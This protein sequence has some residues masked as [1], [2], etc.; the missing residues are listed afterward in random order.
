MDRSEIRE[1]VLRSH[2][3][4]SGVDLDAVVEAFEALGE[5]FSENPHV[6]D[7]RAMA[8]ELMARDAKYVEAATARQVGLA[9]DIWVDVYVD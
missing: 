2:P 1:Y 8:G 7:S 9:F 5:V 3:E 6:L 4:V